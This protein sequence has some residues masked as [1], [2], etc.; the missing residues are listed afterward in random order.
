MQNNPPASPD[1]K[2]GLASA[3]PYALLVPVLVVMAH[4]VWMVESGSRFRWT[5]LAGVFDEPAILCCV[6]VIGF[7]SLFVIRPFAGHAT[8]RWIAFLLCVIGFTMVLRLFLP[9]L[10]E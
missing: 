6:A 1:R 4:S 7:I 5:L 2:P 10:A 3:A 8:S 9:E